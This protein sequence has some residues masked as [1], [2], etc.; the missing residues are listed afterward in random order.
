MRTIVT[1]AATERDWQE[2]RHLLAEYLAWL[3]GTVGLDL[4]AAQ[5]AAT[6]EFS[7]LAGFYRPDEGVLL[8]ARAG[9][10]RAGMAAVH[11]LAGETGELKRMYVSPQ[12]RGLG[13]G[14]TLLAAAVAAAA[15]LGF[16]ELRLQT[17]PDAMGDADRLYRAFG[18]TD[19]A[20]YGGLRVDGVA[21]LGLDLYRAAASAGG[22]GGSRS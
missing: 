11:R 6:A 17:K 10:R 22:A 2:A 12:A 15:D 21:T 19:V 4:P 16:A 5:P 7:D 1:R 9:Q 14:R 8:L 3:A 20:P 18:F 13:L